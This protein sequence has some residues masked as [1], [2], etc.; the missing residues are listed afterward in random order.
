[1]KVLLVILACIPVFCVAQCKTFRIGAQGDTLN[2]VDQQ[3]KKQGKWVVHVEALRGE[4]GYEE[5]GLYKDDKKE[6]LWRAYNLTGDVIAMENYRW[7]NKNGICQYFTIDGLLREESWRAINPENPY[8]TIEVPDPADPYK[9]E[10]KVVKIDGSSIKH[11]R[12]QFFDPTNG[13][14]MKT[15]NYFMGK[16]ED[17]NKKFLSAGTTT[18]AADSTMAIRKKLSDDSKPKEVADFEKKSSKKKSVKIRDGKVG[19]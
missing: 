5:E 19:Y 3:D 17:P 6:G 13:H 1:M 8:D 11:G 14:I 4:A 12:W 10:M 16:L 9:V 2:C 18:I 15:E 7:G